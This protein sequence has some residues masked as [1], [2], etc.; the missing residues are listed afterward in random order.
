MSRSQDESLIDLSPSE[1]TGV[2]AGI[3]TGRGKG[4]GNGSQW[5]QHAEAVLQLVQ[6][7]VLQTAL[8]SCGKAGSRVGA[9]GTLRSAQTR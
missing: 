5:S 8:D 1:V 6:M 3:R 7:C 9:E 2:R 4:V